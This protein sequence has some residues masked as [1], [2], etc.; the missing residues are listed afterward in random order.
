MK[1]P[2]R[3]IRK[4]I[5]YLLYGEEIRELTSNI[6]FWKLRYK[7]ANQEHARCQ[8]MYRDMNKK[9]YVLNSQNKCLLQ[10]IDD[11]QK[12]YAKLRDE[13]SYLLEHGK[14]QIKYY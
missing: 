7:A 3:N 9:Q 4:Q 13:Y 14:E 2:F 1:N 6:K 8:D 12:M 5:A 11:D 10:S